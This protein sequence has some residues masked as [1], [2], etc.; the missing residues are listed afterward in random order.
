MKTIRKIY[1]A[2]LV[3][4]LSPMAANADVVITVAEAGGDVVFDISGSL[5]LTGASSAG[6]GS[7]YGRGIIGGGNNWYVAG[8]D[9][10]AWESYALSAFDGSFGTL[11]TYFSSPTS[12][13][14]DRFFIWGNGG[15]VQQVGVAQGYVSGAAISSSFLFSGVTFANLGLIEGTYDYSIPNSL[16]RM[17]IGR[18]SVPEPSTF[19]LLGLGLAGIGFARRKKA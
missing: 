4:L 12:I 17:N 5:D 7:V 1:L 9:G 6:A 16:I 10:G 14:G 3:V 19:A 11:L 15:L 2:A 18:V 13:A 8:G